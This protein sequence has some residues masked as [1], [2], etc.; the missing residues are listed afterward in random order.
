[1][2]TVVDGAIRK[3]RLRPRSKTSGGFFLERVGFAPN[4]IFILC[5]ISAVIVGIW[6]KKKILT[7]Q[8]MA[9]IT[10]FL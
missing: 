1:M 4:A 7:K 3:K 9:S 6:G 5:K 8:A 2:K 10:N